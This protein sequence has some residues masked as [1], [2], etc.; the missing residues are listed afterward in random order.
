M[1]EIEWSPETRSSL[2][3][4][5]VWAVTHNCS[6]VS[7]L[8]T[9]SLFWYYI[10]IYI[11]KYINILYV[12]SI[13]G[14][15]GESLILSLDFGLWERERQSSVW[16]AH[17]HEWFFESEEEQNTLLLNLSLFCGHGGWERERER[18][19][20]Y[21]LSVSDAALWNVD[22]NAEEGN[23]KLLWIKGGFVWKGFPPLWG[24]V[25]CWDW[26]A[27]DRQVAGLITSTPDTS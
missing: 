11:W 8:G 23:K 1:R 15:F 26:K 5:G 7:Q 14:Q 20:A 22:L 18:G 3:I 21:L 10:Y 19:R 27:A 2:W 17:D 16:V 9:R 24:E 6:I 12:C 25:L 13:W 4:Y